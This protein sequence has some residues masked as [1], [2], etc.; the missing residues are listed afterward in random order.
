MVP[1]P[2]L[3]EV[4]PAALQRAID[5][6]P[7]LTLAFFSFG[8]VMRKKTDT[9]TTE[10][11][12][13]TQDIASALAS[14]ITFS[15]GIL[16]SNT[17]C[18]LEEGAKR[19]VVEFRPPQKTSLWLE[20]AEDALHVPLPGLL[21]I[22]VTTAKSN[23]DYLVFAVEDRPTCFDVPLYRAPL[24]NI[25]HGGGICWGTVA[26]VK[27]QVL[28]GNSL[29]EDWAQLLGTSFGNHSVHGKC[30]SQPQDVRRL[31]IEMEKRRARAY[32]KR[33]LVAERRSLGSILGVER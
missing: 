7:A 1:S 23:P 12:V 9:G 32:P 21:L 29:T 22:R 11:P 24:P 16:T 20:G 19:T 8:C 25:Y 3:A 28:A 17:I 33:E 27:S 2:G 4:G 14:N 13:S 31:Y 30:V 18:I 15:T 5:E 6:Q 10:Y 26:K